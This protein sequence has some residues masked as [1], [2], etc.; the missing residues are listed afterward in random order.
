[1]RLTHVF[2]ITILRFR[3]Y[4]YRDDVAQCSRLYPTPFPILAG[5]EL[6]RVIVHARAALMFLDLPFLL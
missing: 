5:V 6:L 4:T 3:F 1:M 2:T